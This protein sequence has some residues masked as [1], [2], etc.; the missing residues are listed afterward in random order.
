MHSAARLRP[1]PLGRLQRPPDSLVGFRGLLL[2]GKREGE[3]DENGRNER[4]GERKG[5][6]ILFIHY[7]ESFRGPCKGHFLSDSEPYTISYAL[8]K[9]VKLLRGTW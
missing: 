8:E 3:V 2:R 9:L 5:R 7:S 1:D 4:R 6:E